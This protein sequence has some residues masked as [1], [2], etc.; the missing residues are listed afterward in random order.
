MFGGT[1]SRARSRARVIGAAV[2][3]AVIAPLAVIASG[4]GSQ[5]ADAVTYNAASVSLKFK[6][7]SRVAIIGTGKSAGDMQKYTNVATIDGVAIDAVVKTVALTG[8][9]I[10]KF[11]EGSAVSTAPPGSTQSA[12]DLL[13]TD[14]TG[15]SGTESMVTYEFTFYEGGTYTGVG[16]GVGVTLT[17][18]A[19]N[20]YD[21]DGLS[22]VK[23]FTDF[24]GFQSY[25]SYSESSTKGLDASDKGNG[26]VRFLSRDGSLNASA[27]TGSYSFTRVKVNYDQVTTLTVR[28]GALGTGTAYYA[29]DFSAGGTWT[30]NGTTPV[31]PTTT[32]NP[33]NNAP[34]TADI[35]TF[36]AAQGTG[37]VFRAADFPY[38][39]IESNA[40]TAVRIASLPATGELEY[41]DGSS[42]V[43]VTANQAITTAD[44]DLGV[45][46]LTPTST[47]D[48]FTFQVSDGLAF[49]SPATLTFEAPAN[50][51]LIDFPQPGAQPGTGSTF[52]S[53]ATA[54]SGLVPVLTSLSPGVCTVS[55]LDIV[56]AA[57]PGGVTSATCVIVATQVGDPSYGRAQAV[58]RQFAITTLQPQTIT[59]TNPGDTAFSSTAISTDAATSAAGRT[60]NLTTLTASVCTISGFTIVPVKPG[61]CSVRASQ[62]GD[63]TYSAASPVTNSFTMLKTAQAITFAQ[64]PT[65]VLAAGSA[66]LSPTTDATGLT[67]A[68]ASTTP[69]VCTVTG[70]VVSYV[71]AGT[72]SLTASQAG[73]A[74]YAAAADVTRDFA[75]IAISTSALDAG[76]VGSAHDQ[77]LVATGGAGGGTWSTP[78]AL[79]DGIA[80]D[81]AT[82]ILGGTPT[83]TFTGTVTLRY[84]EDGATAEVA[85][86]YSVVAAAAPTPQSITFLRPPARVLG[87]GPATIA[88]TTDA[89]GLTVSFAST[90]P[91]VC[92]VSGTSVTLVATGSCSITASQPGDGT[93]AAAA[94]VVQSFQIF[95]ITTTTIPAG[96]VGTAYNQAVA[97]AGGSGVGYWS[98][99]SVLPA[100]LALDPYNGELVGTPTAAF[101]GDIVVDYA[102]DRASD[103]VTLHLVIVAPKVA[104]AITFPAIGTKPLSTGTVTVSPTTDAAGLAVALVSGTASVCTVSGSAITLLAA[105]TCTITASQPGD[106]TRLAAADVTRSFRVI[107]V[108][109]ASLAAGRVGDAYTSPQTLAGAAGGGTWHTSSTLPGLTVD[110]A[111]GALT[112]TPSTAGTFRVVV[113]YTEDGATASRA[114]ILIVVPAS[115]TV[116][117]T[118]PTTGPTDPVTEPTTEPVTPR[119]TRYTVVPPVVVS[120]PT[121]PP[122]KPA[123]RPVV[124]KDTVDLGGDPA[125]SLTGKTLGALSTDE[126]EQV[127][128]SADELKSEQLA[129]YEAFAGVQVDVIGAKTVATLA[130]AADGAIDATA[131]AQAIRDAA[132]DQSGSFAR[133]GTVEPVQRPTT[134]DRLAISADDRAYFTLSRLD[135]PTA[136]S[137]LDTSAASSWMH[138]SVDITGYKPGTTAYL[139]MTSSPVV[140]G[141]AVVGPDGTAHL[142]G[143][144]ALD[145]LPAGVHRLRVVGDREIGMVTADAAGNVMLTPAQLAEIQRF[146]QGTDAAVR[147]SGANATG[148]THLALRIVPLDLVVPWWLLWMLGALV[149]LLV[150]ARLARVAEGVAGR[151]IKRGVLVAGAAVPVAV[152]L[153]IDFWPLSAIAG[154]ILAVGLLLTFVVPVVRDGYAREYDAEPDYRAAW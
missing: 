6:Q 54:D 8:V 62:P 45:L 94:D 42:W 2:V 79:P 33:F 17:N 14:I 109:T 64:P 59:F 119:N 28:I 152:G 71:A 110:T 139:T 50:S 137:A 116:P 19:I 5:P 34:T 63:S 91:A 53:G 133:L 1:I 51:Q 154:G 145:V 149:L 70:V 100:G 113:E 134:V 72:C 22:G 77:T 95:R 151:W 16:S 140:F 24:R 18:V 35:T 85:L 49:S 105:G 103:H 128:R 107:A 114:L 97:V 21:V 127:R 112:G 99:G 75:I 13:Q 25:T 32:T 30:T 126:R 144:M 12:D 76:Q 136:L 41:F 124:T 123:T 146:D 23:Q 90:T 142:E 130:I 132:G 38:S 118:D 3:L 115:V 27:T 143:D 148:G 150:A 68:L 61:L 15:S 129:G 122:T 89:A 83:T 117:V 98:T 11:D 69:A 44:L 48:S 121:T 86:P 20:S 4:A 93:R 104:Q 66:T 56:A 120:K 82:G 131:I 65:S 78:D 60:V 10:S 29:L 39:D 74:T 7:A 26:I 58:T 84:T 153:V 88:A 57:L 40:F 106:A 43:P 31:T 102:E 87:S 101:D 47:G 111:T 96:S 138:F 37:Y 108:T 46:R 73:S 36:Y 81:P 141:S 55:G 135:E 67:P 125:T 9:T 52:A 147:L 80:L 92:T